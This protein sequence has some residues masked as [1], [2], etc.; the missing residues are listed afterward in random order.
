MIAGDHHLRGHAEPVEKPAGAANC[1]RRAR[2]VTSPDT[3]T[4]SGRWLAYSDPM[5]FGGAGLASAGY[6]WS[7]RDQDRE[8]QR[9]RVQR[10]G[11]HEH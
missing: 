8:R 5:G 3:T 10:S 2:C 1:A 6:G 7:Y 4:T 11:R 9:D